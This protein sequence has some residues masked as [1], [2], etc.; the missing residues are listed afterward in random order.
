MA[1]ESGARSATV[2]A[3]VVG[4]TY[5]VITHARALR[6]AGI[7]VLGLVGRDPAKTSARAGQMGILHAL[8]DLDA[9]LALPGASLVVVATPP[10]THAEITLAAIAAGKHVMCE[11]PFALSLGEARAMLMAAER[12]G[13]VHMLGTEYRFTTTQAAVQRTVASGMIGQ[14]LL[15]NLVRY[16]PS[17]V[18][19]KISLPEWWESAE[20]GGGWLGAA[21]SHLIDQLRS[22]LGEVAAL[23]ASLGRV[24]GRPAMTADDTYTIHFRLAGGCTGVLQGSA[25][26]AGPPASFTRI[27]G[28]AGSVWIEPACGGHDETVWVDTGSGPEQVPDPEDLPRVTPDPPAQDLLPP[29]ALETGW[30]TKGA[31]L[32][33][34]T[35]LYQR[36]RARVI[37]ES[38]PDD[39][40]AATFRDG[41]AGQ[42]V[43]DAARRSAAE[44]GWVEVE[45]A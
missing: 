19:P 25:A 7:D 17:L 14:P 13:T 3:V 40:P 36:L 10:H 20:L 16:L 21:G 26:V 38:V 30:H 1:S 2:G 31:D 28:T 45:P 34:F 6:R 4:T 29:Y 12:A 41:V 23:S 18:N 9:A 44:G 5:G 22:T 39:P 24:S 11:K 8:T 33:P 37:G 43:L 35:R 32:A 27:S 42:S 15:A